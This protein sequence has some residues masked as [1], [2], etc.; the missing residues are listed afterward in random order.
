MNLLEYTK[1]RIIAYEK[2][3]KNIE[4]YDNSLIIEYRNHL[5]I[6]INLLKKYSRRFNHFPDDKKIVIYSSNPEKSLFKI[7]NS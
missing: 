1:L 6:D 3:A 7:F 5:D 4:I 2:G